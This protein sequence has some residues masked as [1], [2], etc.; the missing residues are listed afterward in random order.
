MK[1][2]NLK[3]ILFFQQIIEYNSWI[4]LMNPTYVA[5]LDWMHNS[6]IHVQDNFDSYNNC[7]N[8]H[9]GITT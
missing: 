8:L 9:P 7:F 5:K 1:W 2:S 4:T 6:Q 3:I